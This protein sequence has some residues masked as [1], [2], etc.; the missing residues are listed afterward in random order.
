MRFALL[1]CALL[2]STTVTEAAIITFDGIGGGTGD[3]FNTPYVESGFDVSATMG[4]WYVG[5]V[6]GKVPGNPQPVIYGDTSTAILQV[7]EST[8]DDFSFNGL[9]I[10]GVAF[11]GRELKPVSYTLEGLLDD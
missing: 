7:T 1:F 8:G 11:D 3:P 4:R 6:G 2:S 5:Q 10:S 9:D